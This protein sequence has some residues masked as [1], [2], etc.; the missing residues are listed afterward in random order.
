MP[1]T[2]VAGNI[3]ENTVLFTQD[4]NIT[5]VD[6][7]SVTVAYKVAYAG[8]LS[9]PF[10]ITYSGAS[11]PATGVIAKLSSGKYV[12]RIDTTLL[13]GYWQYEWQGTGGGQALLPFAALVYNAP[14]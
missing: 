1:Q 12:V 5:P 13:P 4:D 11:V 9:G 6:P 7:T 2:L 8:G 3:L 14:I 10:T